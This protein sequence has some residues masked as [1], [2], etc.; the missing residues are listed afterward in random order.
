[1]NLNFV[2]VGDFNVHVDNASNVYGSRLRALFDAYGL[3]QHAQTSTHDHGHTLHLVV[4]FDTT[5]VSNLD[6]QDMH[7]I[8]DHR[9]IQFELPYA[10][11][12]KDVRAVVTRNRS[13]L[14]SLTLWTN[15]PSLN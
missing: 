4:T 8:S 7:Q 13:I 5:S 3:C 1:M 15:W 2:I 9:Y 10:V 14:T 12:Q 6:V 11:T